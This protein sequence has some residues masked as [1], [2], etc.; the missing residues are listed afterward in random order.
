MTPQRKNVPDLLGQTAAAVADPT[1]RLLL[2]ALH[3]APGLTTGELASLAPHRSRFATMKHVR[4][5][6][7]AG[8]V[9]IMDDG[10]R[11]RHFAEPTALAG[12]TTWL[13]SLAGGTARPA[14]RA[15]PRPNSGETTR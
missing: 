5:L 4:V 10:R 9:R 2:E 7:R 3:A 11:R 15:D 14:G 1:R 8:L 13:S 12:L 6:E